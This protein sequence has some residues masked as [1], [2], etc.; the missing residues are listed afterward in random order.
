MAAPIIAMAP[1]AAV[2]V[3]L[4]ARTW[5]YIPYTHAS[6]QPISVRAIPLGIRE[7][8][9]TEYNRPAPPAAGGVLL[10]MDDMCD[11]LGCNAKK[12]DHATAAH[13]VARITAH[14]QLFPQVYAEDAWLNALDGGIDLHYGKPGSYRQEKARIAYVNAGGPAALAALT[15][16]GAVHPIPAGGALA[17]AQLAAANAYAAADPSAVSPDPHAPLPPRDAPWCDP[18]GDQART[19]TSIA[20]QLKVSQWKSGTTPQHFFDLIEGALKPIGLDPTVWLTIIPLMIPATDTATRKWVTDYI[21]NPNPRLSWNTARQLFTKRYGQHDY[22]AAIKK[23]YQEC[24]QSVG[25]PAQGY[26]QRFM[27]LVTELKINEKDTMAIHH[28]EI[29][30]I[31]GLRRAIETVRITNRTTGSAP[32]SEWDYTSLHEISQLAI[33][34]ETSY[35]SRNNPSPSTTSNSKNPLQSPLANPSDRKRKADKDVESGTKIPPRSS[36]LFHKLRNK[37]KPTERNTKRTVQG[38]MVTTPSVLSNGGPNINSADGVTCFRC[39]KVGHFARDCRSPPRT[40]NNKSKYYNR[41]NISN[42]KQQRRAVR[43]AQVKNK[44]TKARISTEASV[45]DK[46]INKNNDQ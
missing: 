40:D 19:L 43:G 11:T 16:A 8:C 10:G 22:W 33:Q 20:L 7:G 37:D 36:K 5:F 23:L 44:S 14:S 28:F 15:A 31:A 2:G 3:A 42:K 21:I 18:S 12:G 34:L 25:E 39:K 45:E 24:R 13:S 4:V 29:G 6:S 38:A 30:L 41:L 17:L 46:V 27:T 9:C 35:N 1:V 32:N 26:S